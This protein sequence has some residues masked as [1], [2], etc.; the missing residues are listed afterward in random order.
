MRGRK[1]ERAKNREIEHQTE[2]RGGKGKI[3]GGRIRQS[4]AGTEGERKGCENCVLCSWYLSCEA[5]DS[6]IRLTI[7]FKGIF[8]DS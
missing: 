4:V 8:I 3:G 1:D 7:H 6:L 2:L 5:F